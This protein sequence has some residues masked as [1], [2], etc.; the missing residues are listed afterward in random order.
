MEILFGEKTLNNSEAYN[1][2]GEPDEAGDLCKKDSIIEKTVQ[3]VKQSNIA[4]KRR[5]CL[6]TLVHI[7][8]WLRKPSKKFPPEDNVDDTEDVNYWRNL[9][10][11]RAKQNDRFLVIINLQKQRIKH[12]EE[13][14]GILMD[15]AQATQKVLAEI[16]PNAEINSAVGDDTSVS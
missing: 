15:M 2:G 6:C 8:L 4:P 10:L 5:F 13:D 11:D 7:I 12:L 9:A 16:S 1:T 3:M 14:L